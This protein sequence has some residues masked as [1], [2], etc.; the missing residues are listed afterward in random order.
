V[1]VHLWRGV[2]IFGVVCAHLGGEL[3][4]LS[5][6]W[7][8]GCVFAAP[9]VCVCVCVCARARAFVYV[10]HHTV[11]LSELVIDECGKKL[12]RVK[13]EYAHL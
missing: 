12:G 11:L 8:G 2:C 5:T 1:C 9:C 10:G 7:S 6:V 13:A 4:S 3:W